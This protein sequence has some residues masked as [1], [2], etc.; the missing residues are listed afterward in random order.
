MKFYPD[1]I[2]TV[3]YGYT[4]DLNKIP[5]NVKDSE[6]IRNEA[7]WKAASCVKSKFFFMSCCFKIIVLFFCND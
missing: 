5:E 7:A 6:K 3:S 1:T 4:K 2:F